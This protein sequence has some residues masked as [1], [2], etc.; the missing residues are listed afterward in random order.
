M[1]DKE[2]R[3]EARGRGEASPFRLLARVCPHFSVLLTSRER[4]VEH[5]SAHGDRS[6]A[7]DRC[8]AILD[9]DFLASTTACSTRVRY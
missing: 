9:A 7:D 2:V 3:G 6:S 1:G 4:R 8:R 5:V